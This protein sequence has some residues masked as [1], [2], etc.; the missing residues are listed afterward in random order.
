M[1]SLVLALSLVIGFASTQASAAYPYSCGQL[2]EQK[3]KLAAQMEYLS[4]KINSSFNQDALDLYMD[5]Y[6]ALQARYLN[7]ADKI[8]NNCK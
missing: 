7:V 5:Q 4:E 6:E 3:A 2:L 8:E 1:K